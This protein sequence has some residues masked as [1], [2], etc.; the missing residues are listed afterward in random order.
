MREANP[1]AH[2]TR[3]IHE[4][5]FVGAYLYLR[6]VELEKDEH[7]ELVGL[8]ASAVAEEISRTRRDDKER[9]YFLRSVLAWILRDIPGLSALYREQLRTQHG[10]SD[11]LSTVAR[12]MRNIGD[13]A[14]GRKRVSEGIQEAADEAR[15]NLDEAAEAIRS[16]EAKSRVN[17]FLNSA[18]QGLRQGLDQ[19][20]DFFRA[21]NESEEGSSGEGAPDEPSGTEGRRETDAAQAARADSDHDVEDAEFV[22]DDETTPGS[23][24]NES[25]TKPDEK[26][27]KQK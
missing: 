16:G 20:G 10:G 21:L 9:V 15:H 2:V 23:S 4:S 13:V 24:K 25:D 7:D 19:L 14:T 12:G 18:E 11:F 3:L 6:D 22:A 26:K 27:R 8:L 17:E 5:N 1:R